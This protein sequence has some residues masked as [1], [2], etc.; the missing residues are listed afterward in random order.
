[1]IIFWCYKSITLANCVIILFHIDDNSE[2]AE[3]SL[4]IISS[5]DLILLFI[6]LVFSVVDMD[7]QLPIFQ[8]LYVFSIGS[9]LDS[10]LIVMHLHIIN[11][12]M[13]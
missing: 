4:P 13:K 5:L 6:L 11:L 10:F 1:M 3:L 12:L 9:I 7:H 2:N 8:S